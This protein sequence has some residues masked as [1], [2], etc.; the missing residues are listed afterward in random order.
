MSGLSKEKLR[1]LEAYIERVY[2]PSLF[3]AAAFSPQTTDETLAAPLLQKKE[4]SAAPVLSFQKKKSLREKRPKTIHSAESSFAEQ[5]FAENAASG[6]EQAVNELDESFSEMLLRKID[7]SGLTDPEVYKAAHIDRK[8]FSK[9]RADRFYRPGKTTALS[10]A[11]ALKL[12]LAETNELLRKAGFAISHSS[13]FDVIVEYF[14]KNGI[15]DLYEINEALYEFDQP[16]L[17]L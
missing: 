6:L 1:D 17:S 5:P 9:I 11:I 7:E 3:A 16:L 2:A 14:I 12:T 15:Y 4:S 13:K 8:L 10:F